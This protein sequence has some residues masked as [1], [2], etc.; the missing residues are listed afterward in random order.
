M[1][2][3]N[4]FALVASP[5]A[6]SL[7]YIKN[8]KGPRIEPSPALGLHTVSF[9]L[10]NPTLGFL[11]PPIF[12]WVQLKMIPSCRNLSN[13]FK[14][15][16]EALLTSS[17]ISKDSHISWA[18]YNKWLKQESLGLKPHWFVEICSFSIKIWKFC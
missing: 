6:R 5:T 18:I 4:N 7:M 8:N 17:P 15:S 14:I 13:A 9:P 3:A 2:S 11:G 1:P 10:K 16:R 12:Y